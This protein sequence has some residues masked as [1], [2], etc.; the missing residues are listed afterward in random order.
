[1]DKTESKG[2]KSKIIKRKGEKREAIES[3]DGWSVGD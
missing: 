2:K 3:V 1:M